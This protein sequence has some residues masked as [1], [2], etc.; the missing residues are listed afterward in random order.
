MAKGA[1][2]RPKQKLVRFLLLAPMAL[3]LILLIGLGI[4]FLS[5]A[6]DIDFREDQLMFENLGVRQTTRIFANKDTPILEDYSLYTA[7]EYD[8]VYGDDN[9]I[10]VKSEDIPELLRGAF[11]SIEDHRF[12]KHGGVDWLRTARAGLNCL[13]RFDRHFGGS[14]ITQQVVKNVLGEREATL[15]RKAREIIRSVKLEKQCSKDEIL[16]IYL[17]IVPLANRCTG[18]YAASRF[19]FNKTPMELT[20]A[21]CATLAAIT[22]LPSRYDP[23]RHIDQ[24]TER[25]EVILREMYRYGYLGEKEYED[26]LKEKVKLNLHPS[27]QKEKAHDWYVEMVIEDVIGDLMSE[28]GLTRAA[29]SR[30]VYGG[31]LSVYTAMDAGAQERVN[32]FF[33]DK[34]HFFEGSGEGLDSA[35]VLICPKTGDI[36]ALAGGTGPKNADR[37]LCGATQL[38]RP[39]GSALK[40]IAL[41]APALQ[42]R[43]I[44]YGTVFWDLPEGQADGGMW[45]HNSPDVYDGRISFHRAVATS[46]NTVAVELYHMLGAERIF[47]ELRMLGIDSLVRERKTGNGRTVSD[48]SAAP[49][50]LGQ[51]TDGVTLRSLVQAYSPLADGG[52]WHKSRSYRAVYDSRGH[53]LLGSRGEEKRQYSEQTAFLMTHTLQEVTEY[54]T[55]NRSS[56]RYLV[57]TA[58]KTGTSG[59][60]EDKWMIGYTPLYLAGLRITS[61]DRSPIG[62]R[63]RSQVEV[64][65]QLM[66]ELHTYAMAHREDI[67]TN[68]Q[69]PEGIVELPFCRDSGC[70]PTELCSMDLRGDRV[71]IGC[72]TPDNRPLEHCTLHIPAYYDRIGGG[73]LTDTDSPSPFAIPIS[74]MGGEKKPTMEMIKTLDRF[75]YLWYYE[76]EEE[77]P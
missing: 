45:P 47:D 28:K 16:T 26:A 76:E 15:G 54:G 36:L 9:Q 74:L 10:W 59:G 20:A 41:Y 39:P 58:G 57:D 67:P 25:R 14:T 61:Y 50:A 5:A 53:L 4:L 33:A 37:L 51:L 71:E 44:H 64:W 27:V 17:N 48:L 6:A 72:F 65:D 8:Y 60:S 43:L 23:V 1:K 30:L 38:K 75:Y 63:A 56:L 11:V 19:Y 22:N 62:D 18:V 2:K 70:L 40:P 31:G 3:G 69:R 52:V 32:R 13:F 73:V 24:N 77:N 68:F 55:A 21:E 35:F 66:R 12:Y 7:I 49:L 46:K 42:D 34:S 29:A